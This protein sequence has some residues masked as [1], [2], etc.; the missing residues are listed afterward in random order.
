MG[1]NLLAVN[2]NTALKTIYGF[3]SNVRKADFYTAFW[4]NKNAF[5]VH[6]VIDKKIHARK[7]R[8]MSGAFADNAVKSMEKY[9]VANIE[10]ACQVLKQ[11]SIVHDEKVDLL[12]VQNVGTEKSSKGWMQPVNIADWCDWL[13]F[14]IMGDLAFGKA[15]GMFDQPQNRFAVDLVSSAAHRHLIVSLFGYRVNW[16]QD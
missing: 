11:N 8:V 9:V 16:R 2:S 3:K 14:D 5:N 15:F 10:G 4:A 12:Q 1:P 13:T 6:N 7:R